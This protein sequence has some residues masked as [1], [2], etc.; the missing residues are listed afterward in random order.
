MDYFHF[1]RPALLLL[2]IPSL[3]LVWYMWRNPPG[4]SHWEAVIDAKLLHHLLDGDSA[5]TPKWPL[6]CLAVAL[7]ILCI[8]I[9]GPTWKRLPQNVSSSDAALII[10]LDLSL[11]MLANDIKPNRVGRVQ[12][13]IRDILEQRDEGLS[14]LIV[15]AGDAHTVV[16]ITEDANT[17]SAMLSSLRPDIMPKLGSRPDLAIELA[18]KLTTDAGLSNASVL[19][20][21]DGI[22]KKQIVRIEK[23]L[24][25]KLQL[26]ILGVG[27]N[28]GGPI[29]LP[30]GGFLKD[31]NNEIVIP[32]FKRENFASLASKTNSKFETLSKNNNDINKLL[33]GLD[34]KDGD[35]RLVERYFDT[36]LDMGA[37]LVLATLPFALI[38]FRRGWLI[39]LLFIMMPLSHN[40]DADWRDYFRNGDQRGA[41][42][43]ESGDASDAAK[44]FNNPD[45]KA[46][47]QYKAGDYLSAAEQFSKSNPYNLGNALAKAGQLQDALSAYDQA[48]TLDPENEDAKLNRQ[49]V[50]NLLKQQEQQEQQQ[51]NDQDSKD[52]SEK[53]QQ[54]GQSPPDSEE[55]DGEQK[56]QENDQSE[57]DSGSSSEQQSKESQKQ[58][59][60]QDNEQQSSQNNGSEEEQKNKQEASQADGES[61]AQEQTMQ[62][63]QQQAMSKEEQQAL[64][65]WLRKVPDDPGGLLRNKFQHQFENNKRNNDYYDDSD[66]IW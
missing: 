32:Q 15:Y 55:Q 10:V 22:T 23:S 21:S 29:P 16:P 9:S 39:S 7:V 14:A 3:A 20:I 66:E 44:H 45:W 46:T 62:S 5:K 40:A 27:T 34:R 52:D 41:N 42:A 63:E 48:L 28:D 36:W 13:K 61:D 65:Q 43:L 6:A 54:E 26:A 19:L 17:I 24:G 4:Q 35:R 38:A 51:G 53:E 25:N 56:E 12:L 37:W 47:A 11:S 59:Q 58:K 64:Q 49:I 60:K 57:N 18:K 31:S 8:A 30:Q 2:L 50:E 33:S 1:L